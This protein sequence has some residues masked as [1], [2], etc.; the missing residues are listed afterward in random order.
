MHIYHIRVKV[1]S[2][3]YSTKGSADITI[4][5]T[6]FVKLVG[7]TLHYLSFTAYDPDTLLDLTIEVT[8]SGGVAKKFELTHIEVFKDGNLAQV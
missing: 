7:K 6:P 5:P 1:T 4:A 3:K 8:F 2:E